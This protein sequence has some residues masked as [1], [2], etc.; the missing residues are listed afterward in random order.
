MTAARWLERTRFVGH[1]PE[2]SIDDVT[3]SAIFALDP[4][5]IVSSWNRGAERLKGYAA[6]E[7]LGRHLSC[8][9]PAE[10]IER[11]VAERALLIA[12]EVG[13]FEHE[14][15]RIRRDGSRFWAEVVI[16]PRYDRNGAL[17]GYTK[18]T[19]D[20]TVRKRGEEQLRLL[21]LEGEILVS[22]TLPLCATEPRRGN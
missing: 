1:P 14:G 16:T 12:R 5:G 11:G 13:R 9:Y 21:A 19:R 3:D 6:K 22:F 20:L 2:P 4:K 18:V 7:I 17:T 10:D 8:F 15:W